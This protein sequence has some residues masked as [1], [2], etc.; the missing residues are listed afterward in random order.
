MLAE[1]R[2]TKIVTNLRVFRLNPTYIQGKVVRI[3]QYEFIL[4]LNLYQKTSNTYYQLRFN[5]PFPH[6][7]WLLVRL[8]KRL[9][10]RLEVLDTGH[11]I[12]FAFLSGDN[13]V[14]ERFVDEL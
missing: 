6:L 5:P 4:K 1:A 2:F 12:R 9:T 14:S 11:T 8:K 10:I 3:N 7:V 13:L